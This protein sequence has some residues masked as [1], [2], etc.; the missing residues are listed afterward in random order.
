MTNN[1]RSWRIAAHAV[2]LGLS[3]LALFPVYWMVQTSFRPSKEIFSTSL[4]PNAPTLDNYRAVMASMPILG[5]LWNT[6]VMSATTTMAQMATA[7]L[8][9]WAL[10]RWQFPGGRI[11]HSL[12]RSHGLSRF[13]WS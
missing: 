8:A 10:V 9:A 4:W 13:R 12:I 7:L 11:V 1:P 5:I 3:F 6:F 2:M